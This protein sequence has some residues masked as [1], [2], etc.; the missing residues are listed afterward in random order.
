M[1]SLP[2]RHA[3]DVILEVDLTTLPPHVPGTIN[4]LSGN[5]YA[6]ATITLPPNKQALS[7]WFKSTDRFY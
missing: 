4:G 5:M 3:N 7:I 1:A 2:I 6:P